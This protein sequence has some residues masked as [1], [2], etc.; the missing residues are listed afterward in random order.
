MN[1]DS[2]KP[3][4]SPFRRANATSELLSFR[5]SRYLERF[6]RRQ[7]THGDPSRVP[8]SVLR[9]MDEHPMVYLAERTITGV[10][11]RPDLYYVRH[12][13]PQVRAEVE[14]WLW[15]LLPSL[16]GSIARAYAYG[17][18]PVVFNW[19][20]EDLVADGRPLR[21]HVH[22]V[23]AHELWP[24]DVTVES[25]N[26]RLVA[27]K[28]GEQRYLAERAALFVWDRE[29]GGW[30]G[31]SA[32]RRAWLDYCRSL[33]VELLHVRY[34]ERSVDSP[35]VA[36]VPSGFVEVEGQQV[37]GFEHVNGLLTELRGSGSLA[38]PNDR[39]AKGQREY[40]ID[41]LN[42]PDRQGVWE[43]ALNRYD[44]GILRAYLVPPRLGGLDDVGAAGARTSFPWR[45][46][47]GCEAG[48][49]GAVGAWCSVTSPP[50]T[51]APSSRARTPSAR[52][53]ARR[54]RAASRA[55]PCGTPAR[56]PPTR[57]HRAT[58]RA[59]PRSARRRANRRRAAAPPIG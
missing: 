35:R 49:A 29:F 8:L 22:Y 7:V 12:P 43:R 51:P 4:L 57:P 47:R 58:W 14:E 9:G 33:L 26:D 59:R 40:E 30:R 34:L 15:P 10:V 6:V 41:L 5:G 19:G 56:C 2:C 54:R 1:P 48:A 52:A 21:G 28:S 36:Y 20:E 39:D 55:P 37:D 17:A 18:I 23:S 50:R 25:R 45:E 3:D 11:R 42:V 27:L 24:G 44:A 16:L 13:D 53:A 32:R 38:L 31:K 46:L